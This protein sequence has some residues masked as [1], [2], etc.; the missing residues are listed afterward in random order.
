LYPLTISGYVSFKS[1]F[2]RT[3]FHAGR[4][5]DSCLLR[6]KHINYPMLALSLLAGSVSFHFC[7]HHYRHSSEDGKPLLIRSIPAEILLNIPPIRLLFG[8]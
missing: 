4:L 8:V 7:R 5:A 6:R 2:T 3:C 1:G